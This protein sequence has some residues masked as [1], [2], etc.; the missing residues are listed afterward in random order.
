MTRLKIVVFQCLYCLRLQIV[1]DE[2]DTSLM[3]LSILLIYEFG[4][5]NTL[6]LLLMLF[7]FYVLCVLMIC[8]VCSSEMKSFG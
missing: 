3:K 8:I 1:V 6:F 7:T 2:F 5:L 4:F